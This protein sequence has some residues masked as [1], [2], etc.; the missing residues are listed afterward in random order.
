V[1][2][3]CSK[4]IHPATSSFGVV[5]QYCF[6]SI[7]SAQYVRV[8]RHTFTSGGLGMCRT[9][10]HRPGR[11]ALYAGAGVSRHIAVPSPR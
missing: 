10:A 9:P 8:C 11:R 3:D 2:L 5:S 7:S 6:N 1:P 4:P